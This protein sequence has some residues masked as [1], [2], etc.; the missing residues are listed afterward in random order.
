MEQNQLHLTGVILDLRDTRVSPA[1]VP[2]IELLVEHRSRQLE[3]GLM[4]EA[5][6]KIAVRLSG[7]Q[8]LPMA[9]CLSPGQKVKVS[10]FLANASHRDTER[11]VLHA[12][13]LEII[14]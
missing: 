13:A 4:R 10:G 2:H 9:S 12:Q 1:G 3:A 6:L 5:R 7:E 8:W 14:D 11:L